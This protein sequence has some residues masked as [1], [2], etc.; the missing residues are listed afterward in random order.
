[1]GPSDSVKE[2]IG[3]EVAVEAHLFGL[4]TGMVIAGPYL[5]H[6][7]IYGPDTPTWLQKKMKRTKAVNRAR[8]LKRAER[9]ERAGRTKRARQAMRGRRVNSTN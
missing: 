2:L 7:L 6:L 5:Y 3:A 8:G 1:M 9:G 4:V